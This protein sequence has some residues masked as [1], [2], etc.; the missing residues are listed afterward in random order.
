MAY[1]SDV[2]LTRLTMLLVKP[3]KPIRNANGNRMRTKLWKRENPSDSAASIVVRGIA[4]IP[5]RKISTLNAPAKS[6]SENDAQNTLL[7]NG[8]R[9]PPAE[10][11][12]SSGLSA[13][14]K[15]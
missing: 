7:K 11:T 2:V 14:K 3:V 4:S 9:K 15:K 10:W 6:E 12:E 5:E 8:C 13:K 1:A